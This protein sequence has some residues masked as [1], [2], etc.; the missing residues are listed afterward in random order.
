M[1]HTENASFT[2][3][4]FE[5]KRGFKSPWAVFISLDVIV[6]ILIFVVSILINTIFPMT[7][8]AIRNQSYFLL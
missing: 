4:A 6:R 3:L 2:F 7:Y 8:Q 5:R 1:L